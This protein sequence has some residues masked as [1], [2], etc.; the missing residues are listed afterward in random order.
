M[1]QKRV[2]R[3]AAP[4]V[5]L[6][7]PPG[8]WPSLSLRVLWESRGLAYFLAWRD[9]KVRYKQTLL[10]ALWAVLQ[11]VFLMIVFSVF[12]GHFARVP[13]DGFPYPLFVFAALLP[14]QLFSQGMFEASQSVVS[15]EKLITRVYFPRLLIPLSAIG[16]PILDFCIAFAVLLGLMAFYG[17]FPGLP[18]LALPVWIVLALATSLGVSL[19]LS[20]LNVRYRDVR[21]TIP[22]LTQ[23]WLFAT[24]V[25]YPS[26]LIPEQFRMLIGLN[27][28][29][30]VVEGFRWSLLGS[31]RMSLSLL[32]VSFSV[33]ALLLVSG[34]FYFRK[35]EHFFADVV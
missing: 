13:S 4:P 25:A 3:R 35:V 31:H 24:P 1:M 22:F 32:A 18:F 15:N 5:L 19:W 12:L 26:S 7:T 33:T 6:I 10:G 29:A 14:W 28:M 23:V 2:Q 34:L 21:Y 30:G 17:V 20:A 16:A 11:P 9:I 27:P 8:F